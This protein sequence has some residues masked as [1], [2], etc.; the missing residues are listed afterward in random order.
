MAEKSV[1][2]YYRLENTDLNW[3]KYVDLF[4]LEVFCDRFCNTTLC[5]VY[6]LVFF[7]SDEDCN[8]NLMFYRSVRA[9]IEIVA[10]QRKF[11]FF[12]I[13]PIE[14]EGKIITLDTSEE[15]N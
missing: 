4:G 12:D 6:R 14:V 13:D 2:N 9:Q 3:R 11:D 1:N 8:K 10:N 7:V 15:K 5:Q